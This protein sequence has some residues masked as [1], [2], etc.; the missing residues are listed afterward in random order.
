MTREYANFHIKEFIA[1][2]PKYIYIQGAGYLYI[3]GNTQ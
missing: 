1:G 3:S 2:G